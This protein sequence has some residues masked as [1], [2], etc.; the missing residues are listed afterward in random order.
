MS[1]GGWTGGQLS[2]VR[3]VLGAYVAFYLVRLVP[4]ATELFSSEGVLPDAGASPLIGLFPNVLGA[5]D[6]PAVVRLW[7][8]AGGAC[9]LALAAGFRT[10]VFALLTWF[11]WA[12]LHGRNPLLA[13]AGVAWVGWLLL[14][15]AALPPRPY[16]ALS[17]RGRVDPAGG[18]EYPREL[19]V[20]LWTVASASYAV[21]GLEKLISASWRNGTALQ[22]LLGGPLSY[23]NGL[24]GALE[25][26][27]AVLL[28]G[29]AWGLMAFELAFAPLALSARW[30][31]R[32]WLV[33][34]ALHGVAFCTIA[35]P[36]AH[37]ARLLLHALLF[38]PSWL[39]DPRRGSKEVV[40][41]DGQC[42]LCHGAVRWLIAEDTDGQRLRFA[43]IHGEAFREAIPDELRAN[44]PDS[45]LVVTAEGE[46]LD[47]SRAV[48]HL[49]RRLGG[50][51]RIVAWSLEVVPLALRDR[52]YDAL[53]K[54]RHRLFHVP[55]SPCPLL[56]PELIRRFDV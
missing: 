19:F 1:A 9:A 6:S 32:V 10:R 25:G 50:G 21:S 14:F 26:L 38:Q 47:R 16:G 52:L 20:V 46:L 2:V 13:D 40:F 35:S 12:C 43:P 5:L 23:A 41:Y 30:R 44:L 29:A 7:L 54:V 48:Q 28:T 22:E 18:W 51:W 31:P 4:H 24:A 17:A 55:D 34:L 15:L 56:T 49:C 53:A 36:D 45:I 37:F 8:A 42:G 3:A 27:P 39:P 33:G 11:V